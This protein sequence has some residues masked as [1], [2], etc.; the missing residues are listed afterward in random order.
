MNKE[1]FTRNRLF[2]E[3]IQRILSIQLIRVVA[4]IVFSVLLFGMSWIATLQWIKSDQALAN[5]LCAV[6]VAVVIAFTERHMAV[7]VH[8]KNTSPLRVISQLLFLVFGFITIVFASIALIGVFYKVRLATYEKALRS[9]GEKITFS[10]FKIVLSPEAVK[11]GRA[12]TDF[13]KELFNKDE[14][15]NKTKGPP[16][17]KG[18]YFQKTFLESGKRIRIQDQPFIRPPYAN[19]NRTDI[20]WPEFEEESQ[21]FDN[22]L[23]QIRPYVNQ[24]SIQYDIDYSRGF[25]RFTPYLSRARTISRHLYAH[26]LIEARKN[27]E[28]SAIQDI[29]DLLKMTKLPQNDSGAMASLVRFAIKNLAISLTWEVLQLENLKE[30]E[31]LSLQQV[32]QNQIRQPTSIAMEDDRASLKA[33]IGFWDQNFITPPES[34]DYL[35]LYQ[36]YETHGSSSHRDV[37]YEKL[38]GLYWLMWK[39]GLKYVD[40]FYAL[41][42]YQEIIDRSRAYDMSTS[43][44]S[45]FQRPHETIHPSFK[46]YMQ[47]CMFPLSFLAKCNDELLVRNTLKPNCRNRTDM[48]LATTAVAL[49]RYFLHHQQYPDNLNQLVPGF[50]ES[51]PVD[52]MNGESLHYVLNP[53]H[54]FT[55]Y[56]VGENGIDDH[57]STKTDPRIYNYNMNLYHDWGS[58]DR[59][60]WE[61][62]SKGEVDEYYKKIM[63]PKK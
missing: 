43:S 28:A 57:G 60:W 61:P 34:W 42:T 50:L 59:V 47:L 18:T 7:T 38:K 23:F 19:W 16:N 41:K 52:P 6:L 27:N 35:P 56:S 24:P 33:Q 46:I 32:L 31:L 15:L 22:L 9:K 17:R 5:C 63:T 25:E 4:Y 1:R 26:G 44:L 29:N 2:P 36:D 10:D 37:Y 49:K 51:V 48:E 30:P 3:I 55:L 54:T 58:L 20:Y 53:N 40:S 8:G 14:E 11:A 62:A 13:G 39:F 21:L 12:L 45:E